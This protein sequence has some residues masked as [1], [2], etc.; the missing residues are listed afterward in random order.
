MAL[1]HD[2][3]KVLGN[4]ALS[5]DESAGCL[6]VEVPKDEI[7]PSLK[8]LKS[9][10]GFDFLSDLFGV[11]NSA[12]YAKKAKKSK[13][14][15]NNEE[16]ADTLS[17][18]LPRFEVIYLLLNLTTNKRLQVRIRVPEDDLTV[19]S[20]TSL[21]KAANWPERECYDMFGIKFKGHPYLRR[22]LMWEEF[23]A[24]PLRKD[25]PL[26]GMGEERDMK[27]EPEGTG[28]WT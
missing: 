16:Q 27:Y 11:D 4:N 3:L 12:L 9:E 20:A 24:H 17:S 13:K 19:E 26:E 7:I 6:F 15:E 23:P 25:Y 28:H 10:L 2:I 1:M 22:L 14:D 18:S 21:W 5:F 8:I